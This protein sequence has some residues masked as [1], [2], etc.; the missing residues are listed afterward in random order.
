M[1][2]GG[3]LVGGGGVDGLGGGGGLVYMKLGP[4]SVHLSLTSWPGVHL[5][6]LQKKVQVP[7]SALTKE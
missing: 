2:R 5:Q 7:F 4:Q 1:G 3:R 6:G